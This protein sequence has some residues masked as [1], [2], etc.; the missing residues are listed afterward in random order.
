MTRPVLI[1]A[2]VL[3]LMAAPAFATPSAPV[4]AELLAAHNA[5][6][7][8]LGLPPLTW[9]EDL[10]VQA[11]AW[12]DHLVGLGALQHSANE[13]R[14]GQG[15]NLWMGTAG[16]YSPAQMVGSWADEKADFS[17]GVFPDGVAPGGDWRKVG[18]Y[19]Q[20]VWRSTTEVGCAIATGGGWDY[21]V[22][23]YS[24]PGNWMGQKPY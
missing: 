24:P 8:P 22:C 7:A 1:L 12:A 21:L 14:P 11:Q 6:R 10:A 3:A 9:N 4:R 20:M 16:Y 2:T 15:E 18:H 23:R 19:T 5:E 17:Y 13:Q